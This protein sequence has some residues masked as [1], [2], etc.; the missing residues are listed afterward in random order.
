[1]IDLV[2]ITMILIKKIKTREIY[3]CGNTIQ[4]VFYSEQ[5]VR[6]VIEWY[7]IASKLAPEYFIDLEVYHNKFVVISKKVP[8]RHISRHDLTE[9]KAAFNYCVRRFH[10]T[11]YYHDDLCAQ[12]IFIDNHGYFHIIDW[13]NIVRCSNDYK[14]YNLNKRFHKYD[15]YFPLLPVVDPYERVNLNLSY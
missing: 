10:N 8:G 14:I 6:N 2:N 12:N 13:D 3:D 1:M 9:L 7:E 4:K 15:T 5:P 11:P